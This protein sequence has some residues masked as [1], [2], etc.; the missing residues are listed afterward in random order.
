[1]LTRCISCLQVQYNKHAITYNSTKCWQ[2]RMPTLVAHKQRSADGKSTILPMFT[3]TS[4]SVSTSIRMTTVEEVTCEHLL[5]IQL[6][7]IVWLVFLCFGHL[8]TLNRCRSRPFWSSERDGGAP[9]NLA[10]RNHLLVWIVKPSGCD[11]TDGHLTS[12]VLTED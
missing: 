3:M 5:L 12:R 8:R 10:P 2:M 7:I 1:M 11:C 4:L 9:R 6:L